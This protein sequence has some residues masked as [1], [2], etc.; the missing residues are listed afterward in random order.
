[1][2]LLDFK[3]AHAY[4]VNKIKVIENTLFTNYKFKNKCIQTKRIRLKQK[5]V[6]G[7]MTIKQNRTCT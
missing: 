4:T 3:N 2:Q 6:F 7:E 1:M 5:K